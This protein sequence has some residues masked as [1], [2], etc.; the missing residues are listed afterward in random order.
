MRRRSRVRRPWLPATVVAL[1]LAACGSDSPDRVVAPSPQATPDAKQSQAN[2]CMPD[3]SGCGFP[4]VESVGVPA[5]T[6]LEPVNGVVTLDQPGQVL[7]GKQVTGSIVVTAP[8]VTIRNVRLVVTDP[9]YGILIRRG[10]D[11]NLL[12]ERSEI[13]MNG[14]LGIKGIAFDGYTLR[15]VFM[16]NGADCAHFNQN[17]VIE[18]SLCAIGADADRD[19]WPDGGADSASCDTGEHLDGFQLGGGGNVVIRHNTVRNPCAQTSAILISHDPGYDAPI[20]DITVADNLLAGGGYTLY[21]ADSDDT[22]QSVTVTG[23][24]FARTYYRD[25]GRYGRHAYCERATTFS[26]NVWD[27]SGGPAAGGQRGAPGGGSPRLA[28]AR[29]RTA[30]KA[31]LR[32]ELGRRYRGGARVRCRRSSRLA[33]ACAVRWKVRDGPVLRRYAGTVRVRRVARGAWR[34]RVRVSRPGGRLIRRA[35][36]LR[37]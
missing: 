10:A 13:D 31:A 28:L 24:R 19:G 5:G 12:V 22:I 30:S 25:G 16:R 26:G 7:E 2:G 32:R 17:V 23:N 34:Y 11:A 3:P 37:A 18:D 21:C 6:R 36:T 29:A 27:G 4:D 33:A 15:K 9:Y 14:R 1:T 8:D 20:R 35:G